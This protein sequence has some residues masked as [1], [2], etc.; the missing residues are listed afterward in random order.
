L[1]QALRDGG[2]GLQ[3]ASSGRR[4]LNALVVAEV[5]LALMLLIGAGLLIR[6][7]IRLQRV[8]TGFN[9]R[10]VLTALVTLPQA[11]YPERNQI[12]P[13]YSQLLER[14]R[15]LPGVQ[16]AAAVSSLPLAGNDTDNSFVIEGRPAP[17]PDQQPVAWVSSV[18]QDYFHTMGMRLLSG[19]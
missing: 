2:R 9:P 14:L 3:A 10:N 4:A 7:F 15:A 13:F 11:V 19:R 12:A 1:N 8:D 18:S 17:P 16:S 5:T 6:S